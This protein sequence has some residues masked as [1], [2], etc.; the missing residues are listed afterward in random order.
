MDHVRYRL[1]YTAGRFEKGPCQRGRV[2]PVDQSQVQPDVQ[3][4]SFPHW[5]AFRSNKISRA[6]VQV[7]AASSL[8]CRERLR[9]SGVSQPAHLVKCAGSRARI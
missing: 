4:L 8:A 2:A 6:R 1:G 9:G 5:Q 7:A 3:V